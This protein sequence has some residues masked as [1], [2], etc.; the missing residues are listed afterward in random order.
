[1]RVARDNSAARV[2]PVA[3]QVQVEALEALA[4][5]LHQHAQLL[6]QLA[7]IELVEAVAHAAVQNAGVAAVGAGVDVVQ[8]FHGVPVFDQQLRAAHLAVQI[9]AL[10]RGELLLHVR[11]TGDGY[12]HK[13]RHLLTHFA[14]Q[15]LYL[16]YAGV[17]LGLPAVLLGL[18]F[19]F[20]V[21][22]PQTRSG[23]QLAVIC[24]VLHFLIR[25]WG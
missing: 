17:H 7:V 22:K 6:R 14:V 4:A 11:R 2:E 13:L 15:P 18:I 9:L 25:K 1:M 24:H 23:Q 5:V 19:A 20:D 21:L 12:A 8:I 3:V 10:E 16:R